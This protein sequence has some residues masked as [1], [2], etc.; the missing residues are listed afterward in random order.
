MKWH[1]KHAQV[2]SAYFFIII[3]YGL[4]ILASAP[5]PPPPGFNYRQEQTP[6]FVWDHCTERGRILTR[7]LDLRNSKYT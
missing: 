5:P 2:L 4:L 7:C 1:S 6:A 3:F